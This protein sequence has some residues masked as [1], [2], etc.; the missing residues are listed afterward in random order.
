MDR[1]QVEGE[2]ER[3]R[4]RRHMWGDGR[5]GCARGRSRR[6]GTERRGDREGTWEEEKK[7]VRQRGYTR[8]DR[9]KGSGRRGVERGETEEGTQG[10]PP[11]LHFGDYL[12]LTDGAALQGGR[13]LL[14]A[15]HMTTRDQQHGPPP[16]RTHRTVGQPHL[17][18]R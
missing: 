5:R 12:L 16:L 3:G 7:W 11:Y 10:P 13:T 9:R 6:S 14:T 18:L 15:C 1:I 2:G 8:G 4:G 17:I